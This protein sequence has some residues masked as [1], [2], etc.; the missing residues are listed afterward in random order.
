MLSISVPACCSSCSKR[1]KRSPV[2]T[3]ERPNKFTVRELPFHIPFPI[4]DGVFVTALPTVDGTLVIAFPTVDGKFVMEGKGEVMR[5][6]GFSVG[7]DGK[8]P[9]NPPVSRFKPE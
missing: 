7:I 1:C 6:N 3:K 2:T 4:D 9:F 5:E 8:S